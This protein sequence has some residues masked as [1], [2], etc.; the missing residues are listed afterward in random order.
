MVGPALLW[1]ACGCDATPARALLEVHAPLLRPSLAT[2]ALLVFVDVLKEI[3]ATF[4]LRPFN[5]DTL[6]IEAYNLAKDE[7]LAEAAAP[8]LVIVAVCLLPLIFVAKRYFKGA[9]G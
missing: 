1:T 4:A 9:R 8:S 2:A 3:P 5:F 6:A 7:R